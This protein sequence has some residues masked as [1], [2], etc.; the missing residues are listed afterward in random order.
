MLIGPASEDRRQDDR[1]GS[2]RRG[3]ERRRPRLVVTGLPV[4]LLRSGVGG[5]VTGRLLDISPTGVRLLVAEPL[6]LGEPLLIE[7]RLPDGSCLNLSARVVRMR[8]EPEGHA[9]GCRLNVPPPGGRL[10]ELRRLAA[11]AEPVSEEAGV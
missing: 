2:G 9:V 10:A 5:V 6:P 7:A 3:G 8:S 1:R 11:G 4:R